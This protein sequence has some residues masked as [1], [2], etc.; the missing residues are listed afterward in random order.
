MIK[1]GILGGIGSG[2]TFVAKNFGYPVFNA[3]LE[4]SKLYKKDK[5]TYRKI[6][7]ILPNYIGSFPI[8]KNEISEAILANK[9]NLK[10]IVG[11]VHLEIRKKMN[12]FL[13]K[14]KN[15]KIIIL[16]IPL[17]LE[18][19]IN[20]KKDILIFV[21]SKRSE[22]LKRLKKRTNFNYKI[23]KRFEEIQFSIE[24]KK[25]RSHF[26]IKNNFTNK[27]VKRS[28]NKILKKIYK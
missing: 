7:K 28:I 5:K 9:S 24:Y 3:D 18:N 23:L 26:I 16:D 11:I 27:S 25:K 8:K 10:K 13:K 6:K 20:K 17:L 1:I 22:I 2:K 15:K 4:V 21:E 19:R 14:N 12:I